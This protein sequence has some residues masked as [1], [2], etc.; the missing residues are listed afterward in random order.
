MKRIAGVVLAG[1]KGRR[2]GGNKPLRPLHGR[3]LIESV[4]SRTRPQVK[5]LWL[6]ANGQSDGL[7][8]LGLPVID[9]GDDHAGD[10]PLAGIA[11]ALSVAKAGGFD[12]LAVVPCDAPFIPSDLVARLGRSLDIA[13]AP[14][15]VV[16]TSQGLQPTFGLWSV[17]AYDACVAALDAGRLRLGSLCGE[18]GM[19]VLSC[20]EGGSD[21]ENS[22]FNINTRND[23]ERAESSL[24]R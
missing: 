21:N 10:G 3:P 12:R 13:D 11:A 17:E 19:A 9:D 2:I 1:G 6:S 18:I 23:L 14:G 20:G 22:F 15:V 4:I 16:R 5:T 24:A 7:G 8:A